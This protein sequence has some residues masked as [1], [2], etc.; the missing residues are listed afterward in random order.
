MFFVFF[1]EKNMGN[2]HSCKSN[3][4]NNNNNNNKDNNNNNCNHNNVLKSKR[5]SVLVSRNGA[6]IGVESCSVF[7]CH[8]LLW[9]V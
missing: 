8:K 4:N 6:Y 5:E 3:N 2:V 9:D 1:A 7:F